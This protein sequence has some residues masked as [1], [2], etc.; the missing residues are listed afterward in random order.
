MNSSL[1]HIGADIAQ[2][3]IDLHG[4]IPGLPARIANTKTGLRALLKVLRGTPR[5]HLVCEAT[6]GCERLLVPPAIKP[7]SPSVSS[8]PVRSATSPAP[9]ASSPRPMPSTPASSATTGVV[10]SPGR[11]RSGA[12]PPETRRP[13]RQTSPASLSARRREKPSP[14]R[15]ALRGCLPAR[16][17]ACPRLSNRHPRQIPRRHRC[18]LLPPSRQSRRSLPG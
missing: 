16:H 2:S 13:L 18:L 8:T 11:L 6:G 15:R 9:R 10:S 14:A 3:H 5:A 12:S 1:V 4:P 7:P 17:P